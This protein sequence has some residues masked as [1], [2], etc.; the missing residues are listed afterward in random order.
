MGRRSWERSFSPIGS[1]RNI[2]WSKGG[3]NKFSLGHT[4]KERYTTVER[5]KPGAQEKR[6]GRRREAVDN[7]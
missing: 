6:Q 3:E 5:D 1:L 7:I 4:D 2:E